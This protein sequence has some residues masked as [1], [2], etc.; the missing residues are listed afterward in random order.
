[1]PFS[2]HGVIGDRT[3]DQRMDMVLDAAR[4][5]ARDTGFALQSRTKYATVDLVFQ[6]P[7]RV[8]CVAV[9]VYMLLLAA[10]RARTCLWNAGPGQVS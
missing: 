6:P 4:G 1:V 3:L 10:C 2:H 7:C 5:V 9:V 8:T